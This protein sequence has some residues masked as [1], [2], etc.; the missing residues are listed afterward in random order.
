MPPF[1]TSSKLSKQTLSVFKTNSTAEKRD[2]LNTTLSGC[3]LIP[4]SKQSQFSPLQKIFCIAMLFHACCTC[5]HRCVITID[6]QLP[7]IKK[8][9]RG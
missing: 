2:A 8:C 4:A 9:E 5:E 6:Q 7:G 1:L 3:L